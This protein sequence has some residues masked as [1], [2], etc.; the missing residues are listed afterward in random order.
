[1][2]CRC[3]A[4]SLATAPASESMNANTG[5][6]SMRNLLGPAASAAVA[7]R[8]SG[9]FRRIVVLHDPSKRI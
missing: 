5:A 1:M 2:V 4:R 6:P 7:C 9:A 8:N 3:T